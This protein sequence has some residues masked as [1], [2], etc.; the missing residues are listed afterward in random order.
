MAGVAGTLGS[1]W[2]RGWNFNKGGL[3]RLEKKPH[4]SPTV[5]DHLYYSRYQSIRHPTTVE[6]PI[7]RVLPRTPLLVAQDTIQQDRGDEQEVGPRYQMGEA[8]RDGRRQRLHE[9]TE[10]VGVTRESPPA[11][12]KVR[13]KN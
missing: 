11:C 7:I 6:L 3:S 1:D 13:V 10:V 2:E 9:I 12:V 5:R 8:A 4:G